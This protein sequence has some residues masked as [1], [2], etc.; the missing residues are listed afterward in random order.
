MTF[1][2]IAVTAFVVAILIYFTMAYRGQ[3]DEKP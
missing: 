3:M 2:T 1:V